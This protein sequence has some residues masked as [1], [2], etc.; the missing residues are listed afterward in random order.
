M[1]L[2]VS[3]PKLHHP[4]AKKFFHAS[5]LAT[6]SH[7]SSNFSAVINQHSS[8]EASFTPAKGLTYGTQP[9]VP[10]FPIEFIPPVDTVGYV[11]V[12]VL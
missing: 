10:S 6:P 11:L 2:R 5:L 1:P 12:K 3:A 4:L 8:T 9:P 7:L